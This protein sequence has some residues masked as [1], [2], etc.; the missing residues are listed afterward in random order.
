ME[1]SVRNIEK[2]YPGKGTVLHDIS[3]RL[4]NGIYGLL[5]PN[6][7]GKT[8]IMNI[9]TAN[10]SPDFGQVLYQGQEIGKMGKKYLRKIGYAP[11]QQWMYEDLRAIEYLYYFAV[12]KG[13]P[14]DI[15]KKRARELL[16]TVNLQEAA[17]QKIRTLSGGMKQRLLLAQAL[18]NDPELII[19]D[20]PTAGLDPQER[21]RIRNLISKVSRDCIVLIATHVVQDVECIAKE[22]LLMK[23]G[24]LIKMDTPDSLIREID[25]EVYQVI[26]TD[27]GAQALQE[28]AA[29]SNIHAV[30]GGYQV[31]IVGK[32]RVPLQKRRYVSPTLEDVYLY[33]MNVCD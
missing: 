33:W 28:T 2:S 12:L 18:L 25:G 22:I 10:L 29:V 24:S 31:R 32:S 7:A 30:S 3:F 4:T 17:Y 5:G 16:E 13:L 1:L 23:Q 27:R 14:K 21:I 20:E 26:A 15:Q 19:L 9:L 6:G 11:Q 8:T